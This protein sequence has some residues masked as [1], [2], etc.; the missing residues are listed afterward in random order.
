MSATPQ[1]TR[2]T[3]PTAANIETPYGSQSRL[4]AAT[5]RNASELI[6][7]R[8][9][10]RVEGKHGSA[11]SSGWLTPAASKCGICVR[12]HKVLYSAPCYRR[13]DVS[14]CFHRDMLAARRVAQPTSS[15]NRS[16][17]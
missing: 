6:D 8:V 15:S 11:P 4:S 13:I 7:D 1:S 3:L 12:P 14:R 10:P 16:M 5:A 2:G 9:L 17:E